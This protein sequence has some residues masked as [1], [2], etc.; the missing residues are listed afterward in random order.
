MTDHTDPTPGPE[1][2]LEIADAPPAEPAGEPAS[3]WEPAAEAHGTQG[4]EWLAQLQQMID[5]VA[6]EAAP[7]ARDVAVKAAELAAVAGDKAGPF[8]RRAAEVTE[9]VGTRVAERSRRFA[10]EVRHRGAE[11]GAPPSDASGDAAGYAA[12]EG[13]APAASESGASPTE[14]PQGPPA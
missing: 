7:V 1:P 5:R 11:S 10:D 14:E 4:R 8:A 3:D 13:P 9:D 2:N 6:A 12:G